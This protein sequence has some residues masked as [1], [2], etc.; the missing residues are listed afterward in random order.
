[1]SMKKLSQA[2]AESLK[3][4][5]RNQGNKAGAGPG[6]NCICPECGKK[7][8]HEVGKPCFKMKCPKC[9]QPML[10]E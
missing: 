7:V 3:G 2:I 8:A 1:M 6:G 5:G 10:R 4:R 9:D